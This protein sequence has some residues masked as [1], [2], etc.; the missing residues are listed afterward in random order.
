MSPNT[1]YNSGRAFEYKRRKH[2]ISEGYAVIRAAG[3]HGPFDLIGFKSA[4]PVLAIQCKRVE[5]ASTAKR[6]LKEFRDSPP[7]QPSKYFRQVMEVYVK[8]TRALIST[9]I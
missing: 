4:H 2:W 3:S 7:L 1:N 6:L 8:D 5:D 9:T